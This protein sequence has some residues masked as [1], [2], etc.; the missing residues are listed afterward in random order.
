VASVVILVEPWWNPAIDKQAIMRV[1]R[2]GQKR[3]V[4]VFRLVMNDSVEMG[5]LELQ[6]KKQ[7]LFDST[8]GLA[9]LA[10]FFQ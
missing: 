10:A 3:P 7:A 6:R 2:I 1:H 5:V 9:D 8:I 4:T